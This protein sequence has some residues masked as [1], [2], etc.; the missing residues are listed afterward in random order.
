MRLVKELMFVTK[1]SEGA[2]LIQLFQHIIKT[3]DG[4]KLLGCGTYQ[5]AE[6]FFQRAGAN[7]EFLLQI[8]YFKMP[9]GCVD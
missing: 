1:I 4:G 5:P 8:A 7:Q 3:N 9:S 6:S 2:C